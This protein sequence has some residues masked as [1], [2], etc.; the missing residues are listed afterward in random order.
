MMKGS[1]WKVDFYKDTGD[2]FVYKNDEKESGNIKQIGS[3]SFYAY[4]Y[5]CD[6]KK[7]S[8]L[9]E[10]NNLDDALDA[11]INHHEPPTKYSRIGKPVIIL[12]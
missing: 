8:D 11:I 7:G 9:G 6:G 3:L 10:Y 2:G 5:Q 12:K 1:N 4:K